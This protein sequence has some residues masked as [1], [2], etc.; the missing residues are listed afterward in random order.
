MLS[1]ALALAA[2]SHSSMSA[3]RQSAQRWFPVRRARPRN[4]AAALDRVPG[5]CGAG[6][7]AGGL[8]WAVGRRRRMTCQVAKART[9]C[10][11]SGTAMDASSAASH[12]S[13]RASSSSRGGMHAAGGEHLPEV[14][15]RPRRPRVLVERLVG[16]GGPAGRD[17]GEDARR[18]RCLR[19]QFSADARIAGRADR[20]EHGAAASRARPRSRPDK[21]SRGAPAAGCTGRT[22]PCRRA[23]PRCRSRR[24]RT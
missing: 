13:A 15:R 22:G 7:V 18:R 2:A 8:A 10:R 11:C 23:C 4:R 20:L 19:S 24:R 1:D 5:V 16:G 9:S 6:P 21:Q 14:T 17:I 3:W 12:C